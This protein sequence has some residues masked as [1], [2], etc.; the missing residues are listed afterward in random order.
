MVSPRG[1]GEVSGPVRGVE[2][3]VLEGDGVIFEAH[4]APDGK[5][6][7]ARGM[8]DNVRLWDAQT[9]KRTSRLGIDSNGLGSFAFS[10][11]GKTILAKH[12]N[13]DPPG[14][15]ISFWDAA[16]GKELRSWPA[17]QYLFPVVF[18]PDGRMVVAARG[19]EVIVW[20]AVSGRE[21]SR[22]TMPKGGPAQG[23]LGTFAFSPDGRT[24]AAG[25]YSG[26]INLWEVST[27]RVRAVLTGHRARISS[28][29]FS[30][31]G[32]RLISGSNDTTALI[33]ALTG[34]ADEKDAKTLTP[35]RLAALWDDLA[36]ADAGKAWRAA[37]A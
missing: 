17:P 8:F 5:T 20:D 10:P 36:D 37:G 18:S 34:L 9:G 33:W 7:A 24:L 32:A 31:D 2:S 15:N 12:D 6:F 1:G 35:E 21:L 25:S 4:F 13:H 19:G 30:P 3:A 23:S 22:M 16:L 11:D 28:L 26:A 29:A 14:S 27:A